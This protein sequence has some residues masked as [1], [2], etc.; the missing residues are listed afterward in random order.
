MLAVKGLG[1][2][3][4]FCPPCAALCQRPFAVQRSGFGV[5]FGSCGVG[6]VVGVFGNGGRLGGE[7][8][9]PSAKVVDVKSPAG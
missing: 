2:T 8:P 5:S 7:R 1:K 9:F 3:R 4:K 6:L